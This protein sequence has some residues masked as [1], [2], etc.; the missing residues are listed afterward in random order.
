MNLKAADKIFWILEMRLLLFSSS[1][2]NVKNRLIYWPMYNNNDLI[3]QFI[4][5]FQGS[6]KFFS[7]LAFVL[8]HDVL[9]PKRM[10][11]LLQISARQSAV[12]GRESAWLPHCWKWNGLQG[13][14][15]R[16]REKGFDQD[17]LSVLSLTVP[18]KHTVHLQYNGLIYSGEAVSCF[19]STHLS[20]FS[21]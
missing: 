18:L 9:C 15:R 10:W 6:I 19:N 7:P 13:I 3:M 8:F 1:G 21:H 12:V 16:E 20:L 11:T 17:Q 5:I 2:F 4:M 14:S